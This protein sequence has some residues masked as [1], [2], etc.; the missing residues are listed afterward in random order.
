MARLVWRSV[1]F[2][3]FNARPSVRYLPKHCLR[4]R[5]PHCQPYIVSLVEYAFNVQRRVGCCYSLKVIIR[6]KLRHSLCYSV[7]HFFPP[8]LYHFLYALFYCFKRGVQLFRRVA[9]VGGESK[10][11]NRLTSMHSLVTPQEYLAVAAARARHISLPV[12]SIVGIICSLGVL[13]FLRKFTKPRWR[14][15]KKKDTS[16][17]VSFNG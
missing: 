11:N 4:A 2:V 1:F 7:Q 14:R 13:Q 15:E 12:L 8:F 6:V 3:D 9:R 16:R 17:D 10:P 5:I